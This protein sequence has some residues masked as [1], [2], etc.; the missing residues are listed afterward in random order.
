[1][2]RALLGFTRYREQNFET[3][4]RSV[5][6]IRLI[7]KTRQEKNTSISC[8]GMQYSGSSSMAY[9]CKRSSCGGLPFGMPTNSSS[10]SDSD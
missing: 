1:M 3:H 4:Y 8:I 7:D 6:C 9:V 10:K 2:W 5:A